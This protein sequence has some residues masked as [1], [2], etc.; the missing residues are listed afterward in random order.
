VCMCVRVCVCVCVSPAS[1]QAA[2][3][4]SADTFIARAGQNYVVCV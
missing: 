3:N 2:R 1:P 4:E